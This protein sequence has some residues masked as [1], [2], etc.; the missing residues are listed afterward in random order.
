MYKLNGY[1]FLVIYCELVSR[2][3]ENEWIGFCVGYVEKRKFQK[4]QK[5]VVCGKAF[6]REI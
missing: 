3:I 4:V 1:L 2:S 5:I 6:F